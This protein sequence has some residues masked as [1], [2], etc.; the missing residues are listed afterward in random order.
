MTRRRSGIVAA[1]A[2]G[3]VAL[4]SSSFAWACTAQ[5][6]V[7][8]MSTAAAPAG[9][10]VKV[11]GQ[12]SPG[13]AVEIRWNG[14]RG[15]KV[16][17]ATAASDGAFAAVGTIPDVEPGV[18]FLAVVSG[19]AAVGRASFEVTPSAA[20][21]QP[22]PVASAAWAPSDRPAAGAPQ[23]STGLAAGMTLLG[24]GSAVLFAGLVIAT[25]AKRRR[26]V[27]A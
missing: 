20:E 1:V 3:A 26:T 10:E 11:T 16:G 2:A 18:Y 22:V 23:S 15:A 13:G 14:A 17:A 4:A 7:F 27:N 19:D 12:A 6:R 24:A 21:G 8:D 5:T 25:V 9:S